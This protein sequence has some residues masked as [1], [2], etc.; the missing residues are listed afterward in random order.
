MATGRSKTSS[1]VTK[2]EEV[3]D[4]RDA[5]RD[6][7]TECAQDVEK[8]MKC[9]DCGRVCYKTWDNRCA[10]YTHEFINDHAKLLVSSSCR[11]VPLQH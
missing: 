3:Q 11:P 5:A 10:V 8:G 7:V 1:K 4:A 6:K 2:K 9:N